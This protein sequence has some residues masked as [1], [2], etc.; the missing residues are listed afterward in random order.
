MRTGVCSSEL[1]SSGW[2]TDR[3]LSCR[4][5]VKVPGPDRRPPD[6]SA[7]EPGGRRLERLAGT[8]VAAGQLQCL[9]RPRAYSKMAYGTGA[10]RGPRGNGPWGMVATGSG[11]GHRI[12]K[13]AAAV[14]ASRGWRGWW[15]RN[16]AHPPS[17]DGLFHLAVLRA[18]RLGRS[19]TPGGCAV[20]SLGFAIRPSR[21]T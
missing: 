16:S 17:D 3:A 6:E 19:K 13:C 8:R 4:P 11:N 21:E 7:P 5:P 18:A 1:S 12:G 20:T 14:S 9:V 15:N 10:S 2:L